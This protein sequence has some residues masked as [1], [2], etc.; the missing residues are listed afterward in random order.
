MLQP[1]AFALGRSVALVAA[2]RLVEALAEAPDPLLIEGERGTGKTALAEFIHESSRPG[3]PFI[4][5]PL[6]ALVDTLQQSELF[7]YARGTFTGAVS[8]RPGLIEAAHTG[9][10]FLDELGNASPAVQATLLDVLD[11]G[12]VTR[13]G[14][15]R[16]RPASVRLIAAT[17]VDLEQCI[18]AGGFR[19]D[20]RDRFG[21]FHVRLPPL[22]ERRDEIVPLFLSSMAK[23]TSEMRTGG[24]TG[25]D[26]V[27]LDTEAAETL[28][29]APW[30]GNIRQVI[31]EA[32]FATRMVRASAVVGVEHLSPDL[33]AESEA[34]V[35]GCSLELARARAAR[36]FAVRA[37]LSQEQGNISATAA[38][39]QVGRRQVFRDL[40]EPRPPGLRPRMGRPPKRM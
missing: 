34:A 5:R 1:R 31:K 11:R 10:L 32:R 20:L 6:P 35:T 17:N 29:A 14:E 9:T 22:R 37:V 21:A 27:L 33:Q 30:P 23:A 15:F 38:R 2:M 19:Q 3:R 36:R 39:F 18:A 25:M 16:E 8:D 40:A 4:K 24:Q 7:G 13:L 12:T 26:P 28:L